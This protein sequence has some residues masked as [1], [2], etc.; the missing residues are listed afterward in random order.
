MSLESIV[1]EN[2][3]QDTCEAGSSSSA[4][5]LDSDVIDLVSPVKSK[6]LSCFQDLIRCE[7]DIDSATWVWPVLEH[8][9]VFSIF[10]PPLLFV[11][12]N[13]FCV[14]AF[15]LRD[16]M[17]MLEVNVFDIA[18]NIFLVNWLH[19]IHWIFAFAQVFDVKKCVCCRAT[20]FMY[21]I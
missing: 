3:H 4:P 8:C 10:L 16:R 20:D 18:V 14:P 12:L 1:C 11:W 13:A 7:I 17:V 21:Y 15:L 2:N 6:P 9:V 19:L 5:T